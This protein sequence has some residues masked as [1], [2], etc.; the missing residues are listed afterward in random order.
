MKNFDELLTGMD[1]LE[2]DK[3]LLLEVLSKQEKSFAEKIKVE[4]ENNPEILSILI[5]LVKLKIIGDKSLNKKYLTSVMT[6]RIS[7][8]LE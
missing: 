5:D 3:K 8:V 4:V 1:I 2:D 6:Q 7:A